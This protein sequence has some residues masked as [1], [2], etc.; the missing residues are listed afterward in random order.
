MA[1]SNGVEDPNKSGDGPNVLQLIL[2]LS[3]IGLGAV[4]V[5]K[6]LNR[7]SL[8]SPMMPSHVPTNIVFTR[9][10]NQITGT[11]TL[12]SA[13]PSGPVPLTLAYAPG[14]YV[15]SPQYSCA[16]A[17]NSPTA[18]FQFTVGTIPSGQ[19]LN[20]T[21]CAVGCTGPTCCVTKPFPP[22]P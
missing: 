13:N 6:A 11:I 16:A 10:G 5:F 8:T 7:R 17:Q 20:I 14:S 22:T 19:Y 1:D 21:A 4:L 15:T 2:G 3:L 18:T 12:D 9:L